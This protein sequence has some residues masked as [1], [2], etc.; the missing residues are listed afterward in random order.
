M[1]GEVY[2]W[3]QNGHIF[4]WSFLSNTK[5]F[6]GYHLACDSAGRDSLLSLIRILKVSPVGTYRTIKLSEPTKDVLAVPNN[7]W[8]ISTRQSIKI[9]YDEHSS[10]NIKECF[11]YFELR[12]NCTVLDAIEKNLMS[13]ESGSELKLAVGDKCLNFWW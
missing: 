10:L 6:P 13:I 3:K 9:F 2:K 12:A 7:G 4:L 1:G 11:D 5:N 8:D